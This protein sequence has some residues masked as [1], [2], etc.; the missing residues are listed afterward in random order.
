LHKYNKSLL[1]ASI[2]Q[3][4]FVNGIIFNII[5]RALSLFTIILIILIRCLIVFNF[6]LLILV[7]LLIFFVVCLNI[8]SLKIYQKHIDAMNNSRFDLY[9]CMSNYYADIFNI[10]VNNNNLSVGY[11]KK[12]STSFFETEYNYHVIYFFLIFFTI[13]ISVICFTLFYVLF[14]LD[15]INVL[16]II[17][18]IKH[19]FDAIYNTLCEQDKLNHALTNIIEINN[20]YKIKQRAIYKQIPLKKSDKVIINK[21][22]INMDY[23]K[24]TLTNQIILNPSDTILIDG[25]S[26]SG[27]TTFVKVFRNIIEL[28]DKDVELKINDKTIPKNFKSISS[29]IYYVDRTFG[30]NMVGSIYE[31]VMGIHKIHNPEIYQKYIEKYQK[32]IEDILGITQINY[33]LNESR[34]NTKNLSSG[35]ISRLNIC[36]TLFNNKILDKHIIIMDETDCGL[37]HQISTDIFNFIKSKNKDKII[38]YISHNRDLKNLKT[39]RIKIYK[40]SDERKIQFI[41]E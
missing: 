21:L 39:K 11:L 36:K 18:I 27:K 14:G 7:C 2:R 19:L 20:I 30:Q 24:A 35:E 29:N 25:I 13:C 4:I 26:G 40:D 10:A 34:I 6:S 22:T 3:I 32:Y 17:N 28:P 15:N 1:Y 8:Y 33:L 23:Y 16:F 5:D 12:N 37:D 9:Y 38:L 41:D 31:I